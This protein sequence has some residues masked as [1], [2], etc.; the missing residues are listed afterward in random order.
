MTPIISRGFRGRRHEDGPP[1]ASRPGST[2]PTTFRSSRRAP[3]RIRHSRSGTSRSTARSTSRAA[4]RG[5]SSSRSRGDGHRRH[6]LRHKVVEARHDLEGRVGRHAARGRRDRGR[7]RRR[8]L[9]RRLHDEPAAGGVTTARPGSRTRYD[10]EPLDPEHG[11]PARLLVPHLYFWKSAKWVRGLTLTS[12][13]EP[14]FW[15]RR[16]PRLRRPV[17]GTAVLGRLTW[18]LRR[19]PSRSYPRRRAS[20]SPRHP[21][22]A[23]PSSPASTSTSG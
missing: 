3:P 19:R 21:G 15:E 20:R 22:L 17:A 6:P 12:T 4:G 8:I 11:G 13:D 1:T 23:G 16:L 2:S 18:Q 10:G 14:G 9:R 7:V 5:R